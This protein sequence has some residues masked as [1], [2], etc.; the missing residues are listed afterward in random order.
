MLVASYVFFYVLGPGPHQH[1]NEIKPCHFNSH[2]AN[3][4]APTQIQP[5]PVSKPPPAMAGQ[6]RPRKAQG[7]AWPIS[8]PPGY[9]EI[10]RG[11]IERAP[12]PTPDHYPAPTCPVPPL[13]NPSSHQT[14]HGQV[15]PRQP[16]F[17]PSLEEQSFPT[18]GTPKASES[19]R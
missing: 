10:I 18:N 7:A 8:G 2:T 9:T 1:S 19:S 16:K 12:L 14:T 11:T 3:L 6:S 5:K 13:T 4:S 17:D 15:S